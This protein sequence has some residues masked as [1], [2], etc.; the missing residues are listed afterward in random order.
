MT[1]MEPSGLGPLGDVQVVAAML[2]ADRADVGSL[3]RVLTG[4]LAAALPADMV[5]VEHQRGLGDRLTGRPGGAVA[6]VVHGE[7]HDLSLR[8]GARGGIDTEVRQI[9]GGVV[10]SRNKVD[11]D[12]WLWILAETVLDVATRTAATRRAFDRFLRGD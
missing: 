1:S 5:E 7:Q 9:V 3:A 2:R 11:L 6:V 4:T 12:T 10:I 8:E